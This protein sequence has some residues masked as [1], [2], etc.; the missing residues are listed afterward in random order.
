[1]FFLFWGG[2]LYFEISKYKSKT[3]NA[4]TTTRTDLESKLNSAEIYGANFFNFRL[5]ILMIED[6]LTEIFCFQKY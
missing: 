4:R 5:I 3:I 6:L 1:M 2:G